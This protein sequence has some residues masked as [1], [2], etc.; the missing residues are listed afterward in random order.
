MRGI[1]SKDRDSIRLICKQTLLR[2][3]LLLS[4]LSWKCLLPTEPTVSKT[5]KQFLSFG[6]VGAVG[7][8][9]HYATLVTLVQLGRL[10]PVLS[11]GV[12]ACVGAVVN[13]RLNYTFTFRSDKRHRDV[14]GKFF[15]VAAVGLGLNVALM[16]VLTRGFSLHYLASQVLATGAVLLWNFAGNRL[17]SFRK[18][19]GR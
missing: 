17:W 14:I 4:S 2:L 7:T 13:Y 5:L 15:A 16:A 10:S 3:D 11:S 6:C 8:A 1:T 12:G 9:S 19:P 18:D